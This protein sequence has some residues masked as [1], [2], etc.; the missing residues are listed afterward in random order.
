MQMERIQYVPTRPKRCKFRGC[1]GS[2]FR[3]GF[4]VF[5][6]KRKLDKE[7]LR[8]ERLARP[9]PQNVYAILA[10]CSPPLVKIGLSR[11]PKNRFSGIQTSSPVKVSLLGFSEGDDLCEKAMHVALKE[12]RS[13]GE[14]FRYE[15][16]AKRAADLIAAGKIAEFLTPFLR[17]RQRLS[18]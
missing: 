4:C 5:H 11:A 9:Q 7:L 18:V 12:Y 2:A 6:Y 10:H 1:V 8:K 17:D 15:G 16:H 14:W 13:H 3:A